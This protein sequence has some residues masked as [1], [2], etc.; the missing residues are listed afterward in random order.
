MAS[1]TS[2][3]CKTIVSKYM[4]EAY[5]SYVA[6]PEALD[7]LASHLWIYDTDITPEDREIVR[8]AL[9]NLWGYGEFKFD[10]EE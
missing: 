10:K 3:Y 1:Y 6:L 7:H 2:A 9:L 5:A 4:G 8:R